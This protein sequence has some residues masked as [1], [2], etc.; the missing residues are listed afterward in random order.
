MKSLDKES[1]GVSQKK[2]YET[3]ATKAVERSK[4]KIVVELGTGVSWF[5]GIF[6][7]ALEATDGVLYTIDLFPDLEP[8]KSTLERYRNNP[9][10]VFIE[11]DSVKIGNMWD[12][13][14]I[15]VLLCDSDH[16]YKRV[17]AELTTW[18]Q[19]K[20][21]FLLVHDTMDIYGKVADPYHAARDFAESTSRSFV[22]YT[23]GEGL[24]VISD[25]LSAIP[26]QKDI[27]VIK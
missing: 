8:I 20:P 7:K 15:D 3:L 21:K 23:Y 11:G 16:S 6:L 14:N 18:S 22:N 5:G 26:I 10:V 13:G 12:E 25:R 17:M 2:L 9:R 4:A 19:F 1:I 24:A 27:D